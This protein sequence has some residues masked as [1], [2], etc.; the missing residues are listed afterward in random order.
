[1]NAM[2]ILN[3]MKKSEQNQEAMNEVV[4]MVTINEEL[5]NQVS[6][7]VQAFSSGYICTISGECNGGKSCWPSF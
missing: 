2:N 5:L 3:A 6:G 7:G 1:M 4:G